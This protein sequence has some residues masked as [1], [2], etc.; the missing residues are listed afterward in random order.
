MKIKLSDEAKQAARDTLP[1]YMINS[2]IGYFE[3]GYAPGSF[4]RAVLENDFMGTFTQADE[5]NTLHL[6]AYAQW[7]R[8]HV[9][10]RPNGWGS[11]EAVQKHIQ[12]CF[13]ENEKGE[14]NYEHVC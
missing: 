9:P 5:T 14:V 8:W 3:E 13:E 11:H 2:L 1:S 12:E 10:G 4:L 7:L 6:R